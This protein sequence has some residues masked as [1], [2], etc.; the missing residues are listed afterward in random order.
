MGDK[1]WK[2]AERFAAEKILGGTGRRYW[3]NSGQD[4]DVENDG[5]VAQVKNVKT[6]SLAQLEDLAVEAERQ[7]NQRN[8]VGLVLVKR[9][10]GR[11]VETRW[12]VAMTAETYRE[13]SGPLPGEPPPC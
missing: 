9:R 1:A 4:V 2:A 5:V 13:M 6:C 3:A 12:L 11:G 8:K 10:G 7:G